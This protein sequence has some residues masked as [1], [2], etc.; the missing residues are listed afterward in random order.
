M[1]IT[2]GVEESHD[3]VALITADADLN[4]TETRVELLG[5]NLVV[6]VE[7]VEISESS[8]KTTDGLGTSGL[9]LGTNVLKN[10]PQ[11]TSIGQQFIQQQAVE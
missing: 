9:D 2:V 5:V 11:E 6:A 3:G 4:L 10:Y 7:G 8:S 1:T